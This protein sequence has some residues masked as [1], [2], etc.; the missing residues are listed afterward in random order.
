MNNS[1]RRNRWPGRYRS[2]GA[3]RRAVGPRLTLVAA[4]AKHRIRRRTRMSRI[5]AGL[6]TVV[7]GFAASAM[8]FDWSDE[9]TQHRFGKLLGRQGRQAESAC[10]QQGGNGYACQVYEQLMQ[11]VEPLN[12]YLDACLSGSR[13][14]CSVLDQAANELGMSESRP[15]SGGQMQDR[16]GPRQMPSQ[17]LSRNDYGSQREY[18]RD[19]RVYSQQRDMCDKPCRYVNPY[20]D[21]GAISMERCQLQAD[22]CRQQAQNALDRCLQGQ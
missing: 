8:A 3:R 5:L 13:Q 20:Q 14:A 12:A 17:Q 22:L 16:R 10:E 9:R 19:C 4:V 2:G 11:A 18:R 7:L 1:A 6:L 15:P 21:G